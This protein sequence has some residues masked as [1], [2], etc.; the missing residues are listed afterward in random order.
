MGDSILENK[1][2]SSLFSLSLSNSLTTLCIFLLFLSL[3]DRIFFHS[4]TTMNKFAT[5]TIYYGSDEPSS[6]QFFRLIPPISLSNQSET[7]ACKY[8][9]TLSRPSTS[10][11]SISYPIAFVI[12]G[13]YW[14]QKYNLD[15]A[16]I[17]DV[18]H[19]F[20]N[21]DYWSVHLEYRR[22][23]AED[24]GK[25][26]WSYTNEDVLLALHKLHEISHDHSNEYNTA[27][28]QLMDIN[29]VVIVGHSAG[30][31]LALWPVTKGVDG[32]LP[33]PKL[34]FQPILSLALAPIGD[35]LEGYNGRLSDDGDAIDRYLKE[36]PRFVGEGKEDKDLASDSPYR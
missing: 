23:N 27:R 24:G 2:S 21:Q 30:G 32:V 11:P 20:S 22:G 10:S 9:A 7:P 35:L 15:N 14:K 34:P 28:A 26:G 29:R 33:L 36:H 25:G 17:T 3:F 5:E 4:E 1:L 31:T 19:Y 16:L 18:A 8:S 6:E 13:G 12:H